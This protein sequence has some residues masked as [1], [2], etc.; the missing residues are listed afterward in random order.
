[1]SVVNTSEF[2]GGLKL[3]LDNAPCTIIEAQFVKPGKGQAFARVKYRNLMNGRVLERTFKS[4]ETAEGADVVDTDM[5]YLYA[6]A[7]G[8]HFMDPESYEQYVAGETAMS[9]AKSWLKGEEICQVTLFNNAPIAVTP[10]KVVTL[11]VTE[12]APAVRGDTSSGATKSVTVETGAE[13]KVPLFVK[14][15]DTLKV[16]TRTGGYVSRG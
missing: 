14:E 2:R 5:Q 1:M 16:D 12:A 6:D 3:M 8:W 9:D 10:P 11:A 7:D 15:G 13:V 4:S